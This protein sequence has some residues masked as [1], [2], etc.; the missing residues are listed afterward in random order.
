MICVIGSTAPDII[1][2]ATDKG[3]WSATGLDRYYFIEF[4]SNMFW[5]G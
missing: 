2:F 1:A 3:E 5:I 4:V